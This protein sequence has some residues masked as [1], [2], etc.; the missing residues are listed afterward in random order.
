MDVNDSRYTGDQ[1]RNILIGSLSNAKLRPL[2]NGGYSVY[3]YL[4]EY[5]I[6]IDHFCC[7]AHARA[8]FKKALE[9]GCERAEFFLLKI[10]NFRSTGIR[11]CLRMRSVSVG[12]MFIPMVS[13][14]ICGKSCMSCLSYQNQR[15]LTWYVVL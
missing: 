9:H 3:M 11:I 10:G 15:C 13:W 5:L 6:D 12:I 4:D 14:R 2:Q 8:K 7:L 1:K